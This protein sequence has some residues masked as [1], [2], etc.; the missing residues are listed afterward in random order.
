MADRLGLGKQF[1]ADLLAKLPEDSRAAVAS[2]LEDEAV[3]GFAGDA[4]LRQ[5]DYSRSMNDLSQKHQELTT[6]YET[7]K[8]AL[9]AAAASRQGDP[10]AQPTGVDLKAVENLINERERGVATYIA[11]ATD[12][13][14]RHFQEFGE[15]LNLTDLLAD[16]EVNKLG[17]L[18]V[19]DRKFAPR[20]AEKAAAVQ[21]ATVDKLVAERMVEE[22]KKLLTIPGQ[23]QGFHDPSPLDVLEAKTSDGA[24]V[25]RAAEEYTALV[26]AK[27]AAPH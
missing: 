3:V 25:Q 10:S 1:L 14:L 19:Y 27:H 17:I 11:A 12:L 22:R 9:A 20:Y 7:N 23:V 26:A 8:A 21:T 16:P 24:L 6:W 18:G 15:R 2:S 5:Q 4:V 13:S